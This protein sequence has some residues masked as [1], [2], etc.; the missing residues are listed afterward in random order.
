MI[1]RK[2]LLEEK[3]LRDNIR[4]MLKISLGRR[5]NNSLRE[6]KNLREAIRNIILEKTAVSDKVPH[7]STAIN[8]LEDLLK[9]IIPV[10]ETDFKSLTTDPE[11]RDSFR[12]HLVNGIENLLAPSE[13]NMAA[14]GDAPVMTEQ[15]YST[16]DTRYSYVPQTGNNIYKD[17]ETGEALLIQQAGPSRTGTNP[18]PS[19]YQP[20]PMP[21]GPAPTGRDIDPGIMYSPPTV[22]V[23]PSNRSRTF[24]TDSEGN[25]IQQKSPFQNLR[26][27]EETIEL[28]LNEQDINVDLMSPDEEKFIDVGREQDQPEEVPPD[29]EDGFASGME[30][31]NLDRTGRNMAY[32]SFKKFEKAIID[33]YDI[34]DNDKDRGTFEDYL[35]T[36]VLLYLDK[37]ED[38][39]AAAGNLPEPTTP[40]YEQEAEAP[41]AGIPGGGLPPEPPPEEILQEYINLDI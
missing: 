7:R 22:Y 18:N 36:N 39:L 33:A 6:E 2:D 21:T 25:L 19:R 27:L 17:P 3:L 38:E 4:D 14:P 10:I 32:S 16:A 5:A 31:S 26:A 35:K 28:F 8:V 20:A 15:T 41:E 12:A 11:Q 30:A 24:T 9:K 1:S 37:F 23:S 34:L 40:E 29:E 13:V